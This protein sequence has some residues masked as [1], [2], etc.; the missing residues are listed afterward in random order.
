MRNNYA[1]A[2]LTIAAAFGIG[3][4]FLSPRANESGTAAAAGTDQTVARELKMI[5][6]DLR[7][8]AKDVRATERALGPD[9]MRDDDD[10]VIG[11]L[12]RVESIAHHACYAVASATTRDEFC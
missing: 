3:S 1:L 9:V 4:A 7:A 11:R 6:R 2:V 12:A 10:S 5:R 8:V